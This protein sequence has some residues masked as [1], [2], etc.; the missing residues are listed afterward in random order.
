[1]SVDLT[2]PQWVVDEITHWVGELGLQNW[3]INVLLEQCIDNNMGILGQAQTSP[4]VCIATIQFRAD[5]QEDDFW[6]R[7]ILHEMLHIFHAD[8]DEIVQDQIIES[9]PASCTE[10]GSM[11]Y[12]MAME[13]FV[14]K[15]THMLW[16]QRSNG[17]RS[18]DRVQHVRRT[19]KR[20][21]RR[22]G[23]DRLDCSNAS[24]GEGS[25]EDV[26]AEA[27]SNVSNQSDQKGRFV[28]GQARERA[29]GRR[30]EVRHA[31]Y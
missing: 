7:V 1:M 13:R 11:A 2:V 16:S 20:L 27:W 3:E 19:R 24:G 9:L 29:Q 18:V 25:A 26:V 6:K 23:E 22:S 17:E 28:K 8:V 30:T 21:A 4:A 10:M 5:I 31:P 15:L 12:Q 14:N